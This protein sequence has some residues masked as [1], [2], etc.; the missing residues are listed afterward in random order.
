MTADRLGGTHGPDGSL[1][2]GLGAVHVEGVWVLR[3]ALAV[4]L[5]QSM[6]RGGGYS[7]RPWLWAVHVERV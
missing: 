4:G 7:G 3:K 1:V 5:G 6:L 2:C